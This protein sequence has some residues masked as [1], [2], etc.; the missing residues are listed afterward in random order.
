MTR[1]TIR[2]ADIDNVD[3]ANYTCARGTLVSCPRCRKVGSPWRE[4]VRRCSLSTVVGRFACGR[5]TGPPFFAARDLLSPRSVFQASADFQFE[6]LPVVPSAP[7]QVVGS[8]RVF[9]LGWEF[10][11]FISGGLGRRAM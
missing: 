3:W 11:P 8:M 9:M 2:G 6:S 1:W 7:G 10:P 4:Q 5:S